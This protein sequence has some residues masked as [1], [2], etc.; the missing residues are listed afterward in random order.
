MAKT[1]YATGASETVKVYSE[2]LFRD[3]RKESFF[4]SRFFGGQDKIVY[5]DSYLT[6]NKGDMIRMPIV[7][8]LTG[9]GVTD[10]ASQLEGNEEKLSS[11]TCDVTLHQYRHAVRDDG[12]LSRQRTQFD[13]PETSKSRLKDWGAEKI[14]AL[15]FAALGLDSAGTTTPTKIFALD[16]DASYVP[17]AYASWAAAKAKVGTV[18]GGGALS[19]DFISALKTWAKTG[20]NRTYVPIR[21]VKVDGKEYFVL[22]THPDALYNLRISSAFQTAMREAEVRGKENP[23]F[24]GATAIWDGVV[25]HAHENCAVAADGG[26]STNPWARGALLGAQALCFAWG[27][28][29]DI[30]EETFDYGNEQ[31]FAWSIIAGVTQSQF[32]SKSY[33]AIGFAVARTAV[34]SL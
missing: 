5:E 4:V 15:C 24:T 26:G 14:D 13:I 30:V 1:S 25:I 2:R 22:L 29:E 17:A 11:Y 21:P 32:N 3:A 33:G 23:L 6:K 27:Q 7:M 19:L 20:G 34:S 12:A 18:S 16:K 10:N 31:G 28:H 8:R 9:S